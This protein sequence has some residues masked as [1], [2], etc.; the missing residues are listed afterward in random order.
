[1]NTNSVANVSPPSTSI[2]I[3]SKDHKESWF[4]HDCKLQVFDAKASKCPSCT[5]MRLRTKEKQLIARNVED[6]LMKA[7]AVE[8][9]EIMVEEQ[10]KHDAIK[11][12]NASIEAA[13]RR[14]K[15]DVKN[16]LKKELVEIKKTMKNPSV[17]TCKKESSHR[18]LAAPSLPFHL[19][20][21]IELLH[22]IASPRLNYP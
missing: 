8:H 4:C 5:T 11:E 22:I 1:M 15:I 19:P 2:S 10:N 21:S 14:G 16:L 12:L 6:I 3:P 9:L 13:A 20:W 17:S 18:Y 7:D